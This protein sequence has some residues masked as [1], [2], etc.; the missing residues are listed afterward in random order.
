MGDQGTILSYAPT[1]ATWTKVSSPTTNNLFAVDGV[2]SS[3]L[4]LYYLWPVGDSV[5]LANAG[6][7]NL[8]QT[9]WSGGP[10]FR[11]VWFYASNAAFA[12]GVGGVIAGFDG[13]NWTTYTSPVT[14]QLNGVWMASSSEA[15]AVGQS[16]SVLQYDGSDWSK[17]TYFTND[18]HAITGL[19][20]NDIWIGGGRGLIYHYDGSIF[21]TYQVLS[22]TSTVFSIWGRGSSNVW[23]VGDGGGIAHWDGVSWT[24]QA[25]PTTVRLYAIGTDISSPSN[26]W[27][28]GE[29]GVILHR[30]Q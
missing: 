12:V 14:E 2:S 21:T 19:S 8:F 28:V 24:K 26:V 30:T 16:G 17:W 29:G 23:A 5:V 13:N 27:A 1:T 18:L 20:S 3:V 11:S 25:S 4:S 10:A 9:Q 6:A 15:Y 22:T 7:P